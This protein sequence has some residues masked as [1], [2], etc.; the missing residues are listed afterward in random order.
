M[1]INKKKFTKPTVSKSTLM[2]KFSSTASDVEIKEVF[3]E[4]NGY[5]TRIGNLINRYA[6]DVPF[7]EESR[8]IERLRACPIVDSVGEDYI[9]GGKVSTPPKIRKKYD[10]YFE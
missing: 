6:V 7:G 8:I 5:G 2:V 3:S 10:E 1:Q 4:I 9:K